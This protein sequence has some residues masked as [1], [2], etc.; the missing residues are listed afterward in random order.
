MANSAR[1]PKFHFAVGIPQD[2]PR[3]CKPKAVTVSTPIP[4]TTRPPKGPSQGGL[5]GPE[6]AQRTPTPQGEGAPPLHLLA[7][8]AEPGNLGPPVGNDMIRAACLHTDQLRIFGFPAFDK[9]R[10]WEPD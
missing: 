6:M 4:Q 3:G 9:I 7:K 1:N 5:G 8:T 10:G 2:D